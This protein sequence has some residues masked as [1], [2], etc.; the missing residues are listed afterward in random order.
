MIDVEVG[1]TPTGMRSFS[2]AYRSEFLRQWDAA[3]ERGSRAKLLRENNLAYGTVHRWIAARDRGEWTAS[4]RAAA[5]KPGRRM[6]SRERAEL[7]QLRKENQQLRQKVE[8]AEAA[9]QILGKAFELLEHVTKSSAPETPA[10]PPALM[11]VAEY[12]QW[13]EGYRLS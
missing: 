8:Q 12:E 2:M 10:I 6:D 13:L 5:E 9:Q 1:R 7:A 4:M 11:S 3:I